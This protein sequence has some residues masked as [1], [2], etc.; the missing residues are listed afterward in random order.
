M[1]AMLREASRGGFDDILV[2]YAGDLT[3][4]RSTHAKRVAASDPGLYATALA[5]RFTGTLL[6][7]PIRPQL[8]EDFGWLREYL[9]TPARLAA[10]VM[11]TRFMPLGN[12]PYQL[13]IRAAYRRDWAR[14]YPKVLKGVEAAE[15]PSADLTWDPVEPLEWLSVQD[16]R[17]VVTAPP[18]D[19]RYRDDDT[20][21]VEDIFEWPEEEGLAGDRADTF[22]ALVTD[23]DRWLA[24]LQEERAGL[25]PYLIGR[26]QA[27][28]TAAP[29][30]LYGTPDAHR[31]VRPRQDTEPVLI[32]RL[33]PGTLP[34]GPLEIRTLTVPQFAALRSKYLN[35][36]ISPSTPRAAFAVLAD[37]ELVGAYAVRDPGQ[38]EPPADIARPLMFL[39]SDF[40]VAPA[41]RGLAK[42]VLLAALSRESRLL[43]EGH[44]K[45]RIRS[46]VTAAYT[47]RPVSMKYRG[48][49]ELTKRGET[50]DGPTTFVLLYAAP[51]GA[52]SLDDALT[53][54][55]ESFAREDR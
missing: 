46:L 21:H 18:I 2:P 32:P 50:P 19:V 23:R 34:R 48:L 40:P 53:R 51:L 36:S 25:E 41:V 1:R 4:V 42:L 15:P 37:G 7:L 31:L 33:Q 28:P 10:A 22:L 47:D 54:W 3:L 29:S 35:A 55:R 49:F 26:L 5:C 39:L 16:D 11:L 6:D 8:E 13:R 44:V 45:H 52:W 12:N 20:A 38:S 9:D 43:I 17:P 24:V 14:L 30:F 27:T